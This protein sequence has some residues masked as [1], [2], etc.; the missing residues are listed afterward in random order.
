M[1]IFWQIVALIFGGL[2]IW[3][4]IAKIKDPIA[5]TEIVR[6]YRL[7]GDPIAPAVA[8]FIP[9]IEVFAGVAVMSG[10]FLRGGAFLLTLCLLFF[11]LVIVVSWGRGLDIACGCFGDDKIVNYPVKIAQNVVLLAAGIGLWWRAEMAETRSVPRSTAT[12]S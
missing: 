12:A 3:S 10:R 9:W 8:L 4:G 7:V 2:F 1:K 11:T 5:F 6:N